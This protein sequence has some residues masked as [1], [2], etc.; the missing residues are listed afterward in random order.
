MVNL[1]KKYIQEF[2]ELKRRDDDVVMYFDNCHSK[3]TNLWDGFLSKQGKGNKFML[4]LYEE[5]QKYL[6]VVS[7]HTMRGDAFLV[8]KGKEQQ[9]PHEGE[10]KDFSKPTSTR[11]RRQYHTFTCERLRHSGQPFWFVLVLFVLTQT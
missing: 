8:G 2:Y 6:K 4:G 5:I 3:L 10:R 1:S 9:Y 7:H 11:A